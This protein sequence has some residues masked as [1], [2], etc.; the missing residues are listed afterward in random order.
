MSNYHPFEEDRF[1]EMVR[2]AH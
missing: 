1:L 2:K